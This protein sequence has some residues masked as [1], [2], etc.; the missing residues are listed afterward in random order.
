MHGGIFFC[1]DTICNFTRT[2]DLYMRHWL[3]KSDPGTYA[4]DD[5]VK[6]KRTE[7]SGIRNFAARLHLRAMEKGDLCLFYHS[8]SNPA[9]CGIVKVVKTFYPDTTAKEG[10]WSSVDVEALKP[11][12]REVSLQ[13]IKKER[14]LQNMALLRISRLSVQPVEED[15]FAKILAM[16]NTKL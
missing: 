9:V 10:D 16:G 15:A 14:S 1:V 13:E 8:G 6:D 11:L 2:N 3:I 12:K 5:L 4:W 7:W